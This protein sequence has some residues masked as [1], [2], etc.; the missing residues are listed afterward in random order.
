MS[1]QSDV[2]TNMLFLLIFEA[3]INYLGIEV[4]FFFYKETHSL[5]SKV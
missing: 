1:K 4:I 2:K 3:Q 5:L